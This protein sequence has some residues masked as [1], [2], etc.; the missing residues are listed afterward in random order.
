MQIEIPT[1]DNP[2]TLVQGDCLD[3]LRSLPDGCVD[4]VVTDPP[5]GLEYD[6]SS[7][8]Q[9]GIQ[10]FKML[11]GDSQPFDIRPFLHFPDVLAWC[12][13][14][15]TVGVPVGVGAWYAWDKVT[16]NDMGVWIGECEYA[17]HKRATK[18]RMFRHLWSGAYRDSEQG[19]RSVHPTQKPVALMRWCL[20]LATKPGDLVLDPFAGSGTT[21]VAALM[22]GRRAILIER[23]PA[24]CDIIRRRLDHA[25]GTGKGSLFAGATN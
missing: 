25:S 11:V 5:Y 15:L 22:E 8:T 4:A 2:V 18:T 17:W 21:G 20:K 3:V 16:R 12:R 9:Q 6:A 10:P 1:A 23:E 13:P 24:Y 7:S 14:Q 19:L